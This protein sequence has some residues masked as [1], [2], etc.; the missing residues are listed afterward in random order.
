MASAIGVS[1]DTNSR[2]RPYVV[3]SATNRRNTSATSSRGTSARGT[4]SAR[5]TSPVPGSSVSRPGR[6]M[7]Q[8]R[9][10]PRRSSAAAAFARRYAANTSP[11]LASTSASIGS[12]APIALTCTNRRTPARS[13]ASANNTAAALSTVSLRATPLPGPAPAEKTAAS[14]PDNTSATSST[15]ACSRSSTTGSA[16]ISRSFSACSG[17]RM[18]PTAVSPLETRSRSNRNAIL[19]CPP[20]TT[21]RMEPRLVVPHALGSEARRLAGEQL[22]VG[23]LV[24]PAPH[25]VLA[26]GET[27]VPARQVEIEVRDLVGGHHPEAVHPRPRQEVVHVVVAHGGRRG[28]HQRRLPVAGERHGGGHP[29]PPVPSHGE[30]TGDVHGGRRGAPFQR[31]PQPRGHGGPVRHRP[32]SHGDAL[33]VGVRPQP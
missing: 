7:V 11:T 32:Q 30:P 12:P 16:P 28:Q 15:L 14:A 29:R 13:A 27:V 2:V 33:G 23:D 6:R 31:R 19:P 3:V 10:R 8:S 9:S 26:E 20:A 18:M 25:R 22:F 21:T 17:L 4:S 1:P 24:H 5:R